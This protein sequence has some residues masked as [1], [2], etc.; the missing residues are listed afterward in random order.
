MLRRRQCAKLY[1]SLGQ[2]Q[3]PQGTHAL[4]PGLFFL[5]RRQAA[6]PIQQSDARLSFS[7]EENL[8]RE[9]IAMPIATCV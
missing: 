2:D 9:R 3:A 5:I 7:R 1:S 8:R 4:L 6:D